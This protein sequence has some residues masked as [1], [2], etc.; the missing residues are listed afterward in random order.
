MTHRMFVPFHDDGVI[1]QFEGYAD[2]AELDWDDYRARYGNIRRLDRI[3]EAEGRSPNQ[4]KVSKQADVLMLFYLLSSEELGELLDGLGY[5]LRPDTIPKTIDYY[6]ARTSHGSTLS[7]VVHAWVLARAHREKAV[8]YFVEAL[9]S[10]TADVQGGTTA[11]GV[12]LAAMAGSVDL[13]QR[14]F[15]GMQTRGDTL[16]FDPYWPEPLGELELVI[17]YRER[18][19]TARVTG[20]RVRVSA[21][22]GSGPPIRIGHRGQTYDLGPGETV[23]LPTGRTIHTPVRR[24]GGHHVP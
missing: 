24:A 1:S 19:L 21:E 14:C 22:P 13:L 15:A 18:E 11:E 20:S 5:R 10:D 9:R 7:A 2:L 4:L 23:E 8:D 17:R 12:H 16:W 3:L 6:L